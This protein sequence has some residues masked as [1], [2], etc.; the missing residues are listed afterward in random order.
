MKGREANLA[1]L[2]VVPLAAA[3]GFT[4][5]LLGSGPVWPVALL[6]GAVGLLVVVLV[7]W[8]SVVV[9]RGL[10]R[11]RR[12]GVITS[13]SLGAVAPRFLASCYRRRYQRRRFRR[14]TISAFAAMKASV[15]TTT[16]Q[17]GAS[18]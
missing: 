12:P 10:R 5:F 17:S 7:P 4:M 13:L 14:Q 18:R 2:V 16:C 11:M 9:R 3:T 8:K 1:L 6:H 15:T